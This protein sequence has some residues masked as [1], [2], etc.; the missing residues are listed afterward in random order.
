MLRTL[1]P[2][3]LRIGK[4]E[5]PSRTKK[6]KKFNLASEKLTT[7][8]NSCYLGVVLEPIKVLLPVLDGSD[9]T[10][11]AARNHLE[12]LRQPD[13]LVAVAH[14]HR[15]S[16]P[17]LPLPTVQ[18]GGARCHFDVHFPVLLPL[19]RL[20][21]AAKGLDEE[22]HP[23]ADAENVGARVGGEVEEPLREGRGAEGMDRVGPAREDDGARAEA[24]EGGERRRAGDAEG[25]DPELPDAAGDEMGVLRTE[26]E[27]EDKVLAGAS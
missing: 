15:L 1:A 3:L 23:V 17:H 11:Q 22:L 27:D 18:H 26:V 25:E 8:S 6:K 5:A 21:G 20:D 7:I 13:R 2:S 19:T 10:L 16:L 9:S 12:P 24:L 4:K 14:P